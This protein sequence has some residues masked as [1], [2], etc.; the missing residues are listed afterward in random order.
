MIFGGA[1]II[2]EIIDIDT[3]QETSDLEVK[4]IS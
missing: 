2:T 1:D 4:L 3:L